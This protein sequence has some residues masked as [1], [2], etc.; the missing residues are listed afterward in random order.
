MI[1]RLI[2][3]TGDVDGIGLEVTYKALLQLS[4]PKNF[5]IFIIRSTEKHLQRSAK[6]IFRKIDKKFQRISTTSI[7]EALSLA[8][9]KNQIIEILS[10]KNEALWVKEAAEFCLQKK[11]SAIV[12]APL[13]KTQIAKAGLKAKGHTDIYKQV[14][15][16]KNIYMA[17]AGKYFNVLLSTDHIPLKQVPNESIK[18]LPGAIVACQEFLQCLPPSRAQKPVGFLGLNPHAGEQGLLGVEEKQL[19]LSNPL[20]PDVAFL[21]KN[22]KKFSVFLCHYHDQALI[23][24]KMVHEQNEAAQI[25]LGLPFVRTSVDHGTA[26]DIF[27]MNKANPSSMICALKWAFKLTQQREKNKTL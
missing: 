17:F 22:W 26:K 9:Q 6:G 21:K 2:I 25:S 16:K 12:N 24:F 8:Y 27:N 7:E 5:Q 14:C 23:P 13:S 3:T 4:L 20:V 11:F 10:Q 1:H 18:R 19:K 15:K